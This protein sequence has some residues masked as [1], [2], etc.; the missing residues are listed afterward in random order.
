[1][2]RVHG[3][4]EVMVGRLVAVLYAVAVDSLMLLICRFGGEYALLI[5]LPVS[6]SPFRSG[7]GTRYTCRYTSRYC[8]ECASMYSGECTWMW[9][10]KCVS[11][12][13]GSGVL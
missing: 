13:L 7:L 12:V 11:G 4:G 1:V 8:G 3:L 2:V 10:S 5:S 6:L 9:S